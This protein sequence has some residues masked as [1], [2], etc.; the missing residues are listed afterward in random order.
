MQHAVG[1]HDDEAQPAI[2]T[3]NYLLA[4]EAKQPLALLA[5]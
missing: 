1:K 5:L 2:Q 4:L 3:V